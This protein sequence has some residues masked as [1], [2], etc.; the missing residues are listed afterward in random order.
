[1]GRSQLS[2]WFRKPCPPI[3]L[4]DGGVST[5]LE[6]MIRQRRRLEIE[7]G[8]VFAHRELWSSSLL[9]TQEGRD[10]IRDCHE[11]FFRAGADIVETVTY[12][13]HYMPLD[14][15]CSEK[16]PKDPGGNGIETPPLLLDQNQVDTMLRDGVRLAQE[17]ARNILAEND[18][19]KGPLYVAASIGCYGGALADG[20]EYTGNYGLNIEQLISFHERKASILASESPDVLAFETVPCIIECKAILK[21]LQKLLSDLGS[22]FPPAWLSLAC[23]DGNHLNDGSDIRDALKL[24]D[25]LDPHAQLIRAVGVNCCA[26][27]HVPSLIELTTQHMVGYGAKRAIVLYPNSGE[28]WDAAREV[29]VENTGI[30]TPEKFADAISSYVTTATSIQ[31]SASLCEHQGRNNT[32]QQIPLIVGGCCR[33]SPETIAAI[34]RKINQ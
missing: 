10:L 28:E 30:T 7:G 27:E 32:V 18:D 29:W 24:I 16:K 1:M 3:L 15:K 8:G 2:D 25:A 11:D 20:S 23:C 17:A 19:E 31:R 9:L 6:R 4:L 26:C 22:Q 13:A 33:T 5:H 21:V 14:R 34:K 12:Q